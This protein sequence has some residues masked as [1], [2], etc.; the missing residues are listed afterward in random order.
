VV[1]VRAEEVEVEAVENA[2]DIR[3]D[4]KARRTTVPTGILKSLPSEQQLV[5]SG[6]QQYF[7][8]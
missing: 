8:G 7:G 2:V 3:E 6:P 4:W 1:E 5:G